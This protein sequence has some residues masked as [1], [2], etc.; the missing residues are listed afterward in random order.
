M[1]FTANQSDLLEAL[2]AVAK[3][4]DNRCSVPILSNVLVVAEDDTLT[5]TTFN[6]TIALSL[7]IE[8]AIEVAG[9]FT[10]PAKFF[11]SVVAPLPD[12]PLLFELEDTTL[13]ISFLGGDAEING[14]SAEDYPAIPTPE[15]TGH[16]FDGNELITAI[17]RAIV[18]VSSDETKLVL[19]GI[20]IA[21]Y[22]D[23][24]EFAATNGHHLAVAVSGIPTP[25]DWAPIT[26]P[27]KA[28]DRLPGLLSKGE[29]VKI[30]ADRSVVRFEGD[31]FALT[32]RLLE[33]Q[34]PQYRQLIPKQFSRSLKFDVS[35][36]RKALT[37]IKP[38]AEQEIDTLIK[39]E[40]LD[41][42]LLIQ[43]KATE[44]GTSE[45][46]FKEI[47][48]Q[49]DPMKWA[50]KHSYLTAGLNAFTGDVILQQN[51]PTSPMVV[52]PQGSDDHLWLMMP[53]QIREGV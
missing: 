21:D 18:S 7:K 37:R 9:E 2:E 30:A 39:L 4:I 24:L 6:Q 46:T 42:A 11:A 36:L 16:S 27:S 43:A 13:K 38:Y 50:C 20:H 5:L 22:N 29:A 33:G 28:M 26:V 19:N 52:T 40:N 53:V 34:Y 45:I 51:S 12:M 49:G 31:R 35:E 44:Q 32:A 25:K 15:A 48:V 47:E 3:I 10:F 17:K 8:A 41:D 1:K 14:I 23:R